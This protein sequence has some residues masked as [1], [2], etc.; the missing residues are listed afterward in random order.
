MLDRKKLYAKLKKTDPDFLIYVKELEAINT[1]L[2]KQNIKYQVQNI[3][4]KNRISELEKQLQEASEKI[5][6][7]I[8]SQDDTP[9]SKT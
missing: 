6:I 4:Y 2:H 3:S 5:R 1:K 7:I 8:S 9:L